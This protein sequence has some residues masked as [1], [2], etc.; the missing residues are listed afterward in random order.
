MRRKTTT[1]IKNAKAQKHKIHKKDK[2]QIRE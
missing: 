1:N 2:T